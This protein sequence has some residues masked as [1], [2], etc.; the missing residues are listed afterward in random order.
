MQMLDEV[1]KHRAY[2]DEILKDNRLLQDEVNRL[3]ADCD[4]Q[5]RAKLDIQAQ[6]LRE[7][8]DIQNQN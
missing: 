3:K 8:Q 1:A 7:I 5:E 6:H 4:R 2:Q